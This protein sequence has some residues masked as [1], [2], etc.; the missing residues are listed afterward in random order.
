MH[1]SF[2]NFA[3]VFFVVWGCAWGLH[4]IVRS[5]L[6]LFRIVNVVI[7]HPQYIDSGYLLWA[8]LLLQFCTDCFETLHVLFFMVCWCACSLGL[9]VRTFS[10]TFPHC[11]LSQF[12]PSIYRH[13]V[14]VPLVSATSLT[15][16]Y[17]S[18]WNFAYICSWYEDVH[19]V[20]IYLLD[21]FMS[22]FPHCELS[23]I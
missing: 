1:R 8:Q 13:W 16:L 18:F 7:F 14:L 2:W 19:M 9:I 12:S 10:S 17:R 23:H 3:C 4:I 6:S 21:H 22:L 5:F 15:V 11:E 20:W